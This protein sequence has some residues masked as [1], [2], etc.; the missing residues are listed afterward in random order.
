MGFCGQVKTAILG[1]SFNPVHCGHIALAEKVVELGFDKVLFIPAS[2]PPH[3]EL[4]RG[5]SDDD[6]LSMLRLA[7][8]DFHWADIWDGEIRRGGHSYTIDTVRELKRAGL[9][10]TRP[11]LII[12]D[13]LAEG[14][15][16]WKHADELAGEVEL[17]VA[18]R[19]GD[20]SVKLPYHCRRLENELWPYSSTQVRDLISK[21]R[22]LKGIVPVSVA[23]FIM[24]KSLYG[25]A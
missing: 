6:R 22:N 18:R 10:G 17:I 1:G 19:T 12:G 3:K 2:N 5:A 15:S 4:V 21:N 14:F 8:A 24:K 7:L 20:D 11:G 25:H 9:V 16:S 23:A 13:D